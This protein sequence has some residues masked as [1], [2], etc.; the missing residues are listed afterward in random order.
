MTPYGQPLNIKNNTKPLSQ[1]VTVTQD[2]YERYSSFLTQC[3]DNYYNHTYR[4]STTPDSYSSN[5][6][7]NWLQSDTVYVINKDNR[8][9][10]YVVLHSNDTQEDSV[11][12]FS[13]FVHPSVCK[14]NTTHLALSGLVLSIYKARMYGSTL[15][16]TY[17]N[18][19]LLSNT[20]NGLIPNTKQLLLQPNLFFMVISLKSL[21]LS[22]LD[23]ILNSNFN[24]S[25]L[26]NYQKYVV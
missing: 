18:H 14:L 10:G 26:L 7:F 11:I 25:D 20:I 16:T 24:Q 13:Y 3:T 23:V 1:L 2:N 22:D 15:I 17:A 5:D 12:S 4:Y 21:S 8:N 9:L 19:P 6:F